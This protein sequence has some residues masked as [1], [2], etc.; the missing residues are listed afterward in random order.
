[1]A[2]HAPE[3]G[4]DHF[5]GKREAGARIDLWTYTAKDVHLQWYIRPLAGSG[6]VEAN[7]DDAPK[8]QPPKIKPEEIRPGMTKQFTFTER[9]PF[10]GAKGDNPSNSILRSA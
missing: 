3:Q 5:G 8:Y 2:R 10:C 4:L 7:A 6:I 9:T 1:M